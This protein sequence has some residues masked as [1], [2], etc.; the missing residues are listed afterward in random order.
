VVV[1]DDAQSIYAFRGANIENILNFEKD[2]PDVRVSNWNKTTDQP[3]HCKCGQ[4][5]DRPQQVSARKGNIYLNE[6]GSL[7]DVIKAGI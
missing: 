7:I 4:L 6:E 1:G 5:G 2:F 3:V